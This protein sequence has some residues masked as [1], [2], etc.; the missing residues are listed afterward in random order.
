MDDL[1]ELVSSAAVMQHG[2]TAFSGPVGEVFEREAD[3]LAAGLEA[4]LAARA[5]IELRRRGWPLPSG[6]VTPAALSAALAVWVSPDG[7]R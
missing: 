7:K 1:A 6:L 3:L 4:P 2:R 5:A